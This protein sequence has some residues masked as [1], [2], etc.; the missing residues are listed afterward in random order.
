M[1]AIELNPENAAALNYLG[2]MLADRGIRL[3]DSISFIER[4]LAID[5]K[6]P[7]YLEPCG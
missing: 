5:P 4:A 2:Y 7:A 1:R 3:Q 6:N